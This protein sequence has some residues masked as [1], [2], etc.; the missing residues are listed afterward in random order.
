[1][2]YSLI[3]LVTEGLAN[4]KYAFAVHLVDQKGEGEI[5]GERSGEHTFTS[6]EE[7]DG[8]VSCDGANSQL[9]QQNHCE[10][11]NDRQD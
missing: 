8:G 10:T 9:S 6:A 11:E 2:S 7:A 1:M 3:S 5:D 4:G